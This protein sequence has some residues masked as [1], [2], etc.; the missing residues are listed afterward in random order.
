MMLVSALLPWL[1]SGIG[2][3]Y[4]Y[5]MLL[6]SYFLFFGLATRNRN[7]TPD[8]DNYIDYINWGST[9]G[10]L[11]DAEFLAAKTL[12]AHIYMTHCLP[13]VNRFAAAISAEDDPVLSMQAEWLQR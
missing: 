11:H 4:R 9:N 8:T 2:S 13:H 12:T 1:F 5:L 10:G 3:R 7:S 6:S